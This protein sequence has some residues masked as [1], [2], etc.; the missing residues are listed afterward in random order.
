MATVTVA[1]VLRDDRGIA[2]VAPVSASA[3]KPPMPWHVV[4][5][6]MLA[7]AAAS[8]IMWF[9]Y[10]RW[11]KPSIIQLTTGYVPFA[12]LVVVTAGLER[13]LE[14]LGRI[15][16][17]QDSA[18]GS[19]KQTAASSKSTA[20]QAAADPGTSAADVALRTRQAALDQAAADARSTQRAVI[21]W[22]IASVCGL[23]ISGGFGFFLLQSVASNHVN[24][25]LDLAVTGL[26]IG[27]GTKPVH[28]L[29]TTIQSKADSASDSA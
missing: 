27:A 3:A 26:A 28:D 22:A 20:Q 24:T 7:V 6:S 14:P 11:I 19:A 21:F 8:V 29:I 23:A 16:L 10:S 9:A 17:P 15:L 12:G 18:A 25:F 2:H 5:F 13:L 4:I 1:N